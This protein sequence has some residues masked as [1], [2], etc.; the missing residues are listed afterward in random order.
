MRQL[1]GKQAPPLVRPRREPARTKHNVVTYRVGI[2]VYVPSRLLGGRIGMHP[3]SGKVV[4]EA[5][6]HVL[7]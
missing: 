1:M 3:H 4:S 5:L 2:G 6:L 7:P